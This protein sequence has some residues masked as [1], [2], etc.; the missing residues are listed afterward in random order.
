MYLN[1]KEVGEQLVF[2]MHSSG[3]HHDDGTERV[4]GLYA[5]GIAF[6]EEVQDPEGHIEAAVGVAKFF[7]FAE[8]VKQLWLNLE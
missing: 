4:P 2:D 1:G 6:P 7:R 3:F 5:N 8:R